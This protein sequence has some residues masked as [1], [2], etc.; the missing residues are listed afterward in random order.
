[1]PKMNLKQLYK[2]SGSSGRVAVEC[3]ERIISNHVKNA[4]NI[5]VIDY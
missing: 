2:P 1:M 4:K 5:L 3:R